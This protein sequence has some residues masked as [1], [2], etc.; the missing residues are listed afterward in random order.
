MQDTRRKA[1]SVMKSKNIIQHES[2]NPYK[3]LSKKPVIE[4]DE[5][6]SRANSMLEHRAPKTVLQ[7]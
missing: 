5:D 1:Q 2:P 6:N 4:V 3:Y 7:T